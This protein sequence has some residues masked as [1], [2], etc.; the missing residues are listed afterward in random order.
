MAVIKNTTYIDM[1]TYNE[2]SFFKGLRWGLVFVVPFWGIIITLYIFYM[3][4]TARSEGRLQVFHFFSVI[5]YPKKLGD[6]I[7]RDN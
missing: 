3:P 5:I 1:N 7:E 4:A 2:I 6:Y